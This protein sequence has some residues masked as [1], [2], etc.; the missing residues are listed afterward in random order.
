MLRCI[1]HGAELV[2]D[3]EAGVW[4]CPLGHECHVV[5]LSDV[6][7]ECWNIIKRSLRAVS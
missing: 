5:S 6:I 3:P 1:V 7:E 2:Y 4:L